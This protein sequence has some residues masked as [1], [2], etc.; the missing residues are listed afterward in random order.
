M[1]ETTLPDWLAR[2]A[3]IAPEAPALIAG[4]TRWSFAALDAQA[5]AAARRLAALGLRPGDRVAVLMRN[6]PLFVALVHAAPRLGV[7]LVLQNTRLAAPE[8][9][10]QLN[11][12]GAEALI[13]DPAF[14]A[15]AEAI[16]Q[17]LP[18]LV[19]CDADAFAALAEAPAALREHIRLDNIHTIIYTSG[20]TGQPKGAMLAYASHWWSAIGSAL[21]LGLRDDDRWV[22]VL[23]FFHVGGLAILMRCAIYGIATVLPSSN[24]ADDIALAIERERGTIISVVSTLLQR[25]VEGRPPPT[26]LRCVLLGGGPAPRQLLE[27]C[28]AL[29]I[30]AIQSYGMTE[31]A[32]QVVTLAFADALRKL[33]SSGKP[34]L[35]NQ[36]RIEAERKEARPGEIGEILIS[37]PSL[38]RG[39][40]NRPDATA[41]ALRDGWLHSGDLGY[42]D[43]EGFLF[44]I[45]RRSDLIISGGENI[46]PAQIEAVLRQHPAVAEAAVVAMPDPRWGQVPAAFV[47]LRQGAA[48]DPQA[49]AE[50]CAQHLARYKLPRQFLALP[51]LPRNAGGKV[52]RAQLRQLLADA[53]GDTGPLL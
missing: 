18:Q 37:G 45:D 9:V 22:A 39:Y 29:G 26:W 14:T 5:S 50:F 48:L 7:T 40:I 52:V 28:A 20:T 31:T 27:R 35:P 41:S 8:L 12:A 43:D 11:D 6:T 34:L 4:E 25:M 24:S 15:L 33:G 32:S 17:Q 53:Q 38:M 1:T 13:Y 10:W 23:P 3:S 51:E 30:P 16:G 49:L 36:I 46:Y 44:V 19:R 42:L 47:V 2:R 21:N